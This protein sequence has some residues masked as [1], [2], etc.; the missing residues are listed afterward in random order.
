[1]LRLRHL[2]VI[3]PGQMQNYSDVTDSPP[4]GRS[5]NYHQHDVTTYE[6]A[7]A[8]SRKPKSNCN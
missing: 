3:Y 5:R 4:G 6:E 1:V 7:E 8:R 2:D